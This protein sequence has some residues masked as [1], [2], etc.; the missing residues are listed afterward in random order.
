YGYYAGCGEAAAPT[1]NSSTKKY[2]KGLQL[3]TP[4]GH[5]SLA[6]YGKEG[7]YEY[8]G[9]TKLVLNWAEGTI[10]AANAHAREARD[11]VAWPENGLIF[12]RASKALACKYEYTPLNSDNSTE[13]ENETNCG[14]VYVSGS[15]SKSL[16]IGAEENLIING[17]IYPTSV[18]SKLGN[19][20][21]G[22]AT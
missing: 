3:R 13:K 8:T 14:N 15:Y 19:E 17:N 10:T 11:T 5:T 20:P 22:T 9:V 2:S 6:T 21:T 7:G 16:T 18:A 1:F 4:E 12:V